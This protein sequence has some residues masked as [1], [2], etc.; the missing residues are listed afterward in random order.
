MARRKLFIFQ[1]RKLTEEN[2][3]STASNIMFVNII[4]QT[5]RKTWHFCV[6]IPELYVSAAELLVIRDSFVRDILISIKI[7][8][9]KERNKL[10]SRWYWNRLVKEQK[11]F[12]YCQ[13]V[14]HAWACISIQ[15]ISLSCLK[16]VFKNIFEN[17][18]TF[19]E[20]KQHD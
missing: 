5:W 19:S 13:V 10:N 2:L 15:Y 8:I 6:Q 18:K 11:E 14:S 7:I 3:F 4:D 20:P 1:T 9:R 12:D 17:C 16:V